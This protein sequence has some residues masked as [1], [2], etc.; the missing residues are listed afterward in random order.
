MNGSVIW[1]PRE[2]LMTM[3]AA[4]KDVNGSSGAGQLL[5][6][7]NTRSRPSDPAEPSYHLPEGLIRP[8]LPSDQEL[9][10]IKWHCFK[11]CL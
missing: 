11:L 7:R 1:G 4:V 2:N 9:Y 10:R 3:E 6:V 5:G 8:C